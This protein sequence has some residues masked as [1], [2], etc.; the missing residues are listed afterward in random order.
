M[1]P[2]REDQ[3]AVAA[4]DEPALIA[5]LLALVS[6]WC[7]LAER[8]P[9][10]PIAAVEIASLEG[11]ARAGLLAAAADL[12]DLVALSP[13]GREAMRRFGFD[14]LLPKSAVDDH[15]LAGGALQPAGDAAQQIPGLEHHLSP[16]VVATLADVVLRLRR[17]WLAGPALLWGDVHPI[18]RAARGELEKRVATAVAR[19]F[20]QSSDFFAHLEMLLLELQERG[21]VSEQALLGLE[22]LVVQGRYTFADERVV[23]DAQQGLG[24][25]GSGSDRAG[26]RSDT[27]DIHE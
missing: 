13:K 14:A 12:R 1:T 15:G 9:Y 7:F 17:A 11:S 19:G 25:A 2:P 16:A 20:L 5:A 18:R 27:G 22:Q 8:S 3:A 24:H 21:V 23:P 6:R 4:G 26:D 10:H